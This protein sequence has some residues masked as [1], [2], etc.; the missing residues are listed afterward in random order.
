MRIDTNVVVLIACRT[1]ALLIQDIG[2]LL[3]ARED[4]GTGIDHNQL[5]C[6]DTF[7]NCLRPRLHLISRIDKEI[8]ALQLQKVSRLWVEA[9]GLNTRR[10]EETDICTLAPDLFRKIV[11]GEK[12]CDDFQ[13]SLRRSLIRRPVAR[14]ETKEKQKRCD[15][16]ELFLLH[17]VPIQSDQPARQSLQ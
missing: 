5:L 11:Q 10:Q 3:F 14:S 6:A 15:Y 4:A 17:T 1:H 13:P 12:G 9:M 16:N 7:Q 8:G 2:A